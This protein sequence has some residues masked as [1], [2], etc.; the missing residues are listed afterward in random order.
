MSAIEP[1]DCYPGRRPAGTGD[2]GIEMSPKYSS[3]QGA[4]GTQS[5]RPPGALSCREFRR[6]RGEVFRLPE[7][8]ERSDVKAAVRSSW[9]RSGDSAALMLPWRWRS[10]TVMTR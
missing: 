2:V 7:I 10:P 9:R 4:I 1:D 6:R 8:G 5:S 3:N